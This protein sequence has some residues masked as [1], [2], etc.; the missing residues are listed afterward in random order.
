MD[1]S[2]FK[3]T[4]KGQEKPDWGVVRRQ[5]H[6]KAIRENQ[7]SVANMIMFLAEDPPNA[8]AAK[9][10]LDELDFDGQKGVW[11]CSTKD[12]GM[13]E[14]WQR[15]ALKYGDLTTTNSYSVW[16]ARNGR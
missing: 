1:M 13:W 2:T 8:S 11:S 6:L 14:T 12:G 15:D 7:V 16:K 4:D 5:V 10:C 9:E 3:S